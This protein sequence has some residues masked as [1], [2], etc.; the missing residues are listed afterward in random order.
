MLLP[1]PPPRRR[2]TD[3]VLSRR[4]MHHRRATR[5]PLPRAADPAHLSPRGVGLR[6]RGHGARRDAG[7]IPRP[8]RPELDA[9]ARPL[10]PREGD[11]TLGAADRGSRVVRPRGPSAG[12]GGGGVGPLRTP[13][14]RGYRR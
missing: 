2:P 10:P 5:G 6:G 3:A 11:G 7:V 4:G 14:G 9:V 8:R 13:G 12:W 1:T